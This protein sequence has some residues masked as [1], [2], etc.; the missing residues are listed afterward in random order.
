MRGKFVTIFLGL[1]GLLVAATVFRV[2]QVLFADK[3][4]WSEAQARVQV[5][6]VSEALQSELRLVRETLELS[7]PQI[8]NDERDFAKDKPYS[9]FQMIAALAQSPTGEWSLEEKYFLEGSAAKIWAPNYSVLALRQLEAKNISIG[10]TAVLSVLDPS[11]KIYFLI[12]SR[13]PQGWLAALAGPELFQG[14]VDRQ[15][16]NLGQVYAVNSLG[17]TLGHTVH[18]YVGSLL[19]DDPLVADLMNSAGGSGSGMF[20]SAQGP[21]QGL[22]EQ[23][24]NSNVFVVVSTQVSQ[25]LGNRKEVQIQ[26][27]LLGLG[28]ALVG[29]AVILALGKPSVKKETG[30]IIPKNVLPAPSAPNPAGLQNERREAYSKAAAGLAHE[31]RGP[32]LSLLGQARLLREHTDDDQ[33]ASELK[34]IEEGAREAHGTLHKMLTFAGEKD[35]PVVETSV[36]EVFKRTLRMMEAKFRAKHIQLQ[37]DFASDLPLIAGQ[38]LMLARAFEQILLNAIESM[39]RSLE[40]KLSIRAVFEN[41]RVVLRIQDSGSGIARENVGQVFDPFFSTKSKAEHSGL[42]LSLALG[43]VKGSGGDI[44]VHSESGKGTTVEVTFNPNA[45][46]DA[47]TTEQQSTSSPAAPAQMP[48]EQNLSKQQ[49]QATVSAPDADLPA[50]LNEKLMQRTLDMIDRLDELQEPFVDHKMQVPFAPAKPNDQS[51]ETF[52]QARDHAEMSSGRASSHEDFM[53][54]TAKLDKPK[55]TKP[56]RARQKRLLEV[57]TQ[58][59]R[60]G[61]RT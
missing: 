59:R 10:G 2:D 38:P 25:I 54:F 6:A 50:V 47:M 36:T 24:P 22:Y 39:D 53:K 16:G 57:P 14:A 9:R 61:E 4:G 40:K 56:S 55:S 29:S 45:D 19:T 15:K 13:T 21:V 51:H 3:L 20:K 41:E 28:F 23:V 35:E 12:V 33:L 5:G 48:A 46:L 7:W 42:G 43:V 1:L 37:T 58:V 30:P 60:P 31:L 18:E 11:R 17:Q 26:L 52:E 49:V 27:I 44:Q 34:K 8:S 32:L